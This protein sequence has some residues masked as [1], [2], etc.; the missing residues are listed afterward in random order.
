MDEQEG[1]VG[2]EDGCKERGQHCY[3]ALRGIAISNILRVM[4]EKGRQNGSVI[5]R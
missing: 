4:R 1:G 3:L 2:K 5:Y